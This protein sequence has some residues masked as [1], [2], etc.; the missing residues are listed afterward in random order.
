MKYIL[1]FFRLLAIILFTSSALCVMLIHILFVG[2]SHELGQ[3]YGK[4]WGRVVAKILGLKMDVEGEVPH[5]PCLIMANHRSYSDIML[6]YTH[7]ASAFVAMAEARNW[8]LIG[9]AAEIVGTIFVDRNN[10]NSRKDTLIQMKKRLLEGFS[11]VVFPEGGTYGGPLTKEFKLGS[12]TL[13]ADNNIPIIP[14]ALDYQNPKDAWVDDSS[15]IEHFVRTFGR[16]KTATTIRF[17]EPI[18]D[19]NKLILLSK[20]QAFINN[21]LIE[22]RKHYDN[23]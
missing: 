10:A 21:S 16:W 19:T 9:Y 20:T 13:A 18:T 3:K 14:T 4:F 2:N 15:M 17:G 1:V 23:P 22:I 7:T 8:P 6:V 5:G 12:F 11:I